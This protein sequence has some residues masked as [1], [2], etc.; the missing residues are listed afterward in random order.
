M[1]KDWTGNSKAIYACHGASSHSDKD[2]QEYDFYAT[3][4]EATEMLLELEEFQNDIWEPCCGCGSISKVLEKYGHNVKSTDLVQR[5]YG[6]GNVDFLQCNETWT[7]DIVT[8]F[9]YNK[10]AE[11]TEHAMELLQEGGKLASFLKLTFL[12]G[13]GRK[14]LFKKYPPKTIYVSSSRLNCAKNGDFSKK[15]ASA[16]CYTWMVWVK[17][18]QGDPTIKWFN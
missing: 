17:G 6:Q 7:G 2:R 3:P 18:F 10:A 11:M 8:N 16:V 15:E 1:S 9:P 12:E 4:H 14:E 13:K 5:E